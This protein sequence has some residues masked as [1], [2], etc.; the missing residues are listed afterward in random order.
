MN[1]RMV[2]IENEHFKGWQCSE[3]SWA[4]SAIRLDTTVAVLAF[5][6]AAQMGFEKHQCVPAS[7]TLKARAQAAGK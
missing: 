4:V 7:E 2:W 1:E 3:C 6:R 5:N